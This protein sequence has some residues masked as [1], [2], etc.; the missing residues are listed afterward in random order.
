MVAVKRAAV[1][2]EGR[3]GEGAPATKVLKVASNDPTLG[4]KAKDADAASSA[5]EEGLPTEPTSAMVV[6]TVIRE[7]H[8]DVIR[9]VAFNRTLPPRGEKAEGKES[10][11]G[12]GE[13][14]GNVFATVGGN[15]AAVYDGRNF[16]NYV[17][18]VV[19]YTHDEEGVELTTC[20]WADARGFT[21]HPKGDLHLCLGASSG[22]VLVLSV[23]EAAITHLLKGHAAPVTQLATSP[24]RPG[25]L[26]SLST[27]GGEVKLWDMYQ[28]RCLATFEVGSAVQSI[29]WSPDGAWFVAGT[30]TG[31]LQKW[32]VEDP[33][34]LS[35]GEKRVKRAASEN[36]KAA[37]AGLRHREAV[38]AI[39][40]AS[41]STCLSKSVDGHVALWDWAAGKSLGAWDV[42]GSSMRC[43]SDL[44]VTQD[45]KYFVVG[46]AKGAVFVFRTREEEEEAKE[47]GSTHT[48]AEAAS[49]GEPVARLEAYKQKDPVRCCAISDDH[50]D[51]LSSLGD[52]FTFRYQHF[53]PKN[54]PKTKQPEKKEEAEAAAA[55][56]EKENTAS[57]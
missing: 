55:G 10:F 15:Q 25:Y 48:A 3:E 13:S 47:R 31:G 14:A 38:D 23:A 21:K 12:F 49:K 9:K 16:G 22:D 39:R 4:A 17:G 26:L 28:E 29:A 27:K 35:E 41:T 20:C 57:A 5:K 1:C 53:K 19:H 44:D 30:A 37:I 40:F 11:C 56:E 42:P 24:A 8:G 2:A 32:P 34:A 6:R 33:K 46:N 52:A 18:L 43:Y 54:N 36:L 45:G 50:R 7:N 51:V